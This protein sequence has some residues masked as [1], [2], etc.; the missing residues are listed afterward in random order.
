M[1]PPINPTRRHIVWALGGLALPWAS[2]ASSA[3]APPLMLA[4]S[5]D[6]RA[7]PTGFWVSEKYDGVRGYWNGQRLL[8]RAGN[9]IASPA[10]FTADWPSTPMEG[11]LWA[12]RGQFN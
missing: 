7:D 10:W 8:T 4:K 11:E 6:G 9:P 1:P 5:Y 3:T 2:P 12:G